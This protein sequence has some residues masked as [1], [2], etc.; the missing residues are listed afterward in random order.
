VTIPFGMEDV[1]FHGHWENGIVSQPDCVRVSYYQKKSTSQ[2][3]IAVA[4]YSN[5]PVDAI[6]KLPHLMTGSSVAINLE[7][8]ERV[9][10]ASPWKVNIPGHDL[11][12]YRMDHEETAQ[13]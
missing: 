10:V 7:S 9:Q 4:N 3:L 12:V 5:Q 13:K 1:E 8:G 6:L 11:R 2:Y